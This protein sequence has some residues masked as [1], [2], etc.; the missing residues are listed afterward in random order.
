MSTLK[1]NNI[2]PY[3]GGTVTITGATVES[4]SY[5]TT[6]SYALNAGGDLIGEDNTWTGQNTFDQGVLLN[7]GASTLYNGGVQS[8]RVNLSGSVGTSP[9]VTIGGFDFGGQSYGSISVN[10]AAGL[11][12]DNYANNG[13]I[14]MTV[15]TNGNINTVTDGF[16]IEPTTT[17]SYNSIQ[18]SS[19]G[20]FFSDYY[21]FLVAENRLAGNPNNGNT[22]LTLGAQNKVVFSAN[23]FPTNMAYDEV[24]EVT[25]DGNGVTFQDWVLPSY[26][27]TPWL[28]I[29]QQGTPSFKRG[30][31]VTGS[32]A[33]TE[34]MNLAPQDP[35]P[36][37]TIGDLAVSGSNLF[38]YNGAWTQVI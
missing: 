36:A 34:A 29:P 18:M 24:F 11:N 8:L 9:N 31:E 38:F 23:A 12:I 1:V 25:V 13:N 5:A 3:S 2:E 16:R 10:E 6:A 37:G 33:V 32:V 22:G 7:G 26:T 21:G 28:T 15:G 4:A 17:S 30:L 35:L 14:R 20:N 19:N 27:P